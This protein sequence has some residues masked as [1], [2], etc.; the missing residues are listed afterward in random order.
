[1]RFR[2]LFLQVAST[3]LVLL[4][5]ATAI[6]LYEQQVYRQ[7]LRASMQSLAES[8]AINTRG[9][10]AFEDTESA[11]QTLQSLRAQAHVLRAGLYR[12][13][14]TVLAAYHRD[15]PGAML[16]TRPMQAGFLETG[17]AL[18]LLHPIRFDGELTG[19]VSLQADRGT[20]RARSVRF[21]LI[22]LGIILLGLVLAALL[23]LRLQRH[24][25]EPVARLAALTQD[26]A[27][28]KDYSV[29][30]PV[31]REDEFGQLMRGFN[32]MLEE[33]EERDRTLEE[34]VT[35][36]T[37]AISRDHQFIQNVLDGVPTVL[38]VIDHSSGRVKTV[39]SRYFHYVDRV[40]DRGDPR[41]LLERLGLDADLVQRIL[42]G[43][44]LQDVAAEVTIE[45]HLYIFEINHFA[46]G[47]EC[48]YLLEID[49]ITHR[50]LAEHGLKVEKTR[51]EVTLN[52][53]VDAVITADEAGKITYLNPVAEKF[54]G[55][56]ADRVLGLQ[57]SRVIRTY[58]VN[59][60]KEL[61][62]PITFFLREHK[63]HPLANR[64]M[65]SGN[66]GKRLVTELTT[67]AMTDEDGQRIGVVLVIRDVTEIRELIAKISHQAS[68][69]SLTGL[70]NRREFQRR[71]EFALSTAVSD[72]TEHA[73][74]YLDLDKFKVVND[75][76]GHAA[77]DQLLIQ[78]TQVMRE[79]VRTG[80][81]VARLGGDEFGILMLNCAQEKA[82]AIAEELREQVSSFRFTWEN[83]VFQVGVSIGLVA[84]TPENAN[85]E[86]S[87]SL[88]DAACY[89]AKEGGR[90]RIYVYDVQDQAF[91][92]RFGQVV[93]ANKIT[94]AL[95]EDRF[96]LVAQKI[97][98]I[99]GRAGEEAHYEILIRMLDEEGKLVPPGI[100]LGAAENYGLMHDIDRW[101]VDHV[102]DWCR[103]NPRRLDSIGKLAI[104][105]SGLSVTDA[106]FRDNM[107]ATIRDSGINGNKLCFEFTETAAISNFEAARKFIEVLRTTGCK[108]SLDDFGT[109]MSSFAYLKNFPVDYLKIDGVFVRNI[110]DNDID[111]AMVRSI[112]EVGHALGMQTIAEF[113][114]D[115]ASRKVL[116]EIGVDFA[117][118]YGIAKPVELDEL[119]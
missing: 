40:T 78:L 7:E 21:A 68:H 11:T 27:A 75:T 30:L 38:V 55:V 103:E 73:L 24:I 1:M 67:A 20:E 76:C 44:D 33:V 18:Y 36:Q 58:H 92:D 72:E 79:R 35:E 113:V 2:I 104:N 56:P 119:S 114:E 80:D 53:L 90:N 70:L 19:Y 16:E 17:E 15:D 10:L 48:E 63:P 5:T 102:L 87:L 88:A 97:Q 50:K 31:A 14:G 41:E 117:Q 9:A 66:P 46:L 71:L 22:A 108:F 111:A 12:A 93:W 32:A 82:H 28:R 26:I 116:E 51:V 34:K 65:F 100:F 83:E 52:S 69:D 47:F 81:T 109:G 96:L 95:E 39:N 23:A 118:G 61:D 42:S 106:R 99:Q 57:A 49:D 8:V 25:A 64:V 3:A 110:A 115:E 59:T 60:E 43:E 94:R 54:L 91:A 6:V 98:P 45:D 4:L 85:R 62:D 77:G 105:L 74:L 13:D 84:I 112:T 37:D 29:R 101:V 86:S 89:A 107:L